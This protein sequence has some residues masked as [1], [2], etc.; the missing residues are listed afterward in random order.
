MVYTGTSFPSGPTDN[1]QTWTWD[2]DNQSGWDTGL[3]WGTNWYCSYIAEASPNG[4]YV[5]MIKLITDNTMG[6]DVAKK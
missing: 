5:Y 1:V 3:T 2:N 4:P 6:P